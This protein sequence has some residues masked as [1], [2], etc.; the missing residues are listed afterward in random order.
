M[1]L[2]ALNMDQNEPNTKEVLVKA[3]EKPQSHP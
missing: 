3:F 1:Y 2:S